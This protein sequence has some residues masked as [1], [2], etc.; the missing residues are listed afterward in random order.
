M[1]KTIVSKKEMLKFILNG[2]D[3]I[4]DIVVRTLGPGGLPILIERIGQS[5]DGTPLPPKITKDG[6]SVADE[7]A[8]DDPKIDVI[9]QSIKYICKKTNSMAGDGTTTAIALGRAILKETFN[10][11]ENDEDLNPQL[12]K[13][14]IEAVSKIVKEELD[15]LSLPI[16]SN[17]MIQQVATISANGDNEIGELIGQAFDHVGAE[18]VV[19]VDEGHTSNITLEV[20]E[21]YQFQRGAEARDGFFNNKEKTHFE[22]EDAAIIIYD[23]KLL[24]YTDILPAFNKIA[25]VTS[26]G[27][28]TKKIPP[29]VIMANEFSNELL[30]F[31]LIQKIEGGLQVCAVKG[32]HMTNVRTGYYEDLA[33]F[34][35]GTKLGS[36]S[37]NLRA[38]EEGDEGLCKRIVIDKYKTTIYDGKGLEEDI[39]ERVEQLK[40][41]KLSAES[42]YDIQVIN[43]R[44]AALTGGIAKIGVGGVTEFEIKEKYDRIE[45]ALNASRAAIQNGIIPGGGVALLRISEKIKEENNLL[46]GRKIMSKALKV[47][48][49]QILENIGYSITEKELEEIL[50]NEKLVLDA[51]NKEIKDYLEAGIIDPVKVTKTAL[52]NAVSIS[53]LLSTAGGAIVI[54]RGNK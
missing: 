11:L 18:G 9:I 45:D 3:E 34:T 53:S 16:S 12:V 24:N 51:R 17:E 6:V 22:A 36:G 10:E 14:E 30:Q 13:E 40:A 25:G 35:G 26:D 31:L 41:S 44:I 32:P 7:C 50:K 1:D 4:A 46:I 42:P 43:D 29:I 23:G 2:M 5:L 52:E 37:K 8:S 19:T 28:I 47:P 48:F 49:M 15:K 38:F 33:A 39:I 27:Q 20:V 54:K 21:G